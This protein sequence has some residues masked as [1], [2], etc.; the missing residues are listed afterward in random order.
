MYSLD[1]QRVSVLGNQRLGLARRSVL[2]RS[3]EVTF[4][5][6]AIFKRKRREQRVRVT[7]LS[8]QAVGND[9]KNF[10]PNFANGV[11]TP[12]TRF[13]QGLVSRRIDSLVLEYVGKTI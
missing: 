12:V 7:V 8:N 6:R 3:V 4:R 5:D 1:N 11:N 2:Q 10:S 9:P 13:I